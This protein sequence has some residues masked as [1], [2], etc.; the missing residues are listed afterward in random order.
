MNRNNLIDLTGNLLNSEDFDDNEA[1]EYINI[2]FANQRVLPIV[3][4]VENAA[5]TMSSRMPRAKK[6]CQSRPDSTSVLENSIKDGEV[7]SSRTN[8]Q[9]SFPGTSSNHTTK[10]SA[11][12][13]N[14]PVLENAFGIRSFDKLD[15]KELDRMFL[16]KAVRSEDTGKCVASERQTDQVPV[17]ESIRYRQESQIDS[18]CDP[19]KNTVSSSD[20]K[21]EPTENHSQMVD[22]SL[23][24]FDLYIPSPDDGQTSSN[25]NPVPICVSEDSLP[26]VRHSINFGRSS[27]NPSEMALADFFSR[28][29]LPCEIMFEQT[30]QVIPVQRENTHQSISSIG[31]SNSVNHSLHRQRAKKSF[32]TAALSSSN[33]LGQSY[34]VSLFEQ[35]SRGLS[36]ST[37][38]QSPVGLSSLYSH[39]K[40]LFR[41][42]KKLN[43][44]FNPNHFN[45]N[46]IQ[47]RYRYSK[48]DNED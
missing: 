6:S 30:T 27:E 5:H 23:S 19:R 15:A 47:D 7:G 31:I 24:L 10:F 45:A 41:I 21:V 9:M 34:S 4:L 48:V 13:F 20:I 1:H 26:A 12:S 33:M 35:Q 14:L 8:S 17:V 36:F 44:Q 3:P 16:V 2:S 18:K 32:K 38:G 28:E 43:N 42:N 37:K 39:D 25:S 46:F 11:T 22:N 29:R 40:C